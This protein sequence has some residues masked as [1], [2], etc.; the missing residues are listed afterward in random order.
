M[1]KAGFTDAY[2]TLYPDEMKN[3]G[4]LVTDVHHR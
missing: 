1:S 4:L 3:P 2:R